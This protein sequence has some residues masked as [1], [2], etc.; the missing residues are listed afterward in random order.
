[1]AITDAASQASNQAN[2]QQI[3]M[4]VLQ[5]TQQAASAPDTQALDQRQRVAI[6]QSTAPLPTVRIQ[7]DVPGPGESA[8]DPRRSNSTTSTTRDSAPAQLSDRQPPH[9]GSAS[10]QQQKEAMQSALS[11]VLNNTRDQRRIDVSPKAE[12]PQAAQRQTQTTQKPQK[13][14]Q[15]QQESRPEPEQRRSN[16]Q[17]TRAAIEAQGNARELVMNVNQ[18]LSSSSQRLQQQLLHHALFAQDAAVTSDD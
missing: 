15:N 17:I 13:D 10:V 8:Q 3:S 1:M 12:D 16:Y 2:L 6:A 9:G 18:A 11:E 7:G 5:P 14:K 4:Q